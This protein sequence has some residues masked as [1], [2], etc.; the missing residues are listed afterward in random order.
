MISELVNRMKTNIKFIKYVY[1]AVLYS[2]IPT[3]EVQGVWV[4]GMQNNSPAVNF[5]DD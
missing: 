4:T 2:C 5:A 1:W 3:D